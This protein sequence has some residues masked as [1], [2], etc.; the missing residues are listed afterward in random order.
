MERAEIVDG[1]F[2]ALTG[3]AERQGLG[4]PTRMMVVDEDFPG[5]ENYGIAVE[6]KDRERR[7]AVRVS[8]EAKLNGAFDDLKARVSDWVR[9]T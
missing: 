8:R 5:F 7:T 2:A 3:F 9:A 4:A 6:W 1:A